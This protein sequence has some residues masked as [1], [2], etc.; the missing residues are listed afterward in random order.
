MQGG[1]DLIVPAAWFECPALASLRD[2]FS[3]LFVSAHMSWLGLC[4]Q[5]TCPW[6]AATSLPALIEC[7]AQQADFD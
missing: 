6:S 5:E 4:G 7:H 3:P 1:A 2:E